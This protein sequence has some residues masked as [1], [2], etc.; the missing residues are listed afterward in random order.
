MGDID[1]SDGSH[2]SASS[3]T[4]E[5]PQDTAAPKLVQSWLSVAKS[6]TASWQRKVRA[7]HSQVTRSPQRECA[8]VSLSTELIDV[9]PDKLD[10]RTKTRR[11][12]WRTSPASVVTVVCPE[13]TMNGSAAEMSTDV[14]STSEQSSGHTT[15]SASDTSDGCYGLILGGHCLPREAWGRTFPFLAVLFVRVAL[16]GWDF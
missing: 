9:V 2:A 13:S 16:L 8:D 10:V 4:F 7:T 11:F 1:T 6:G 3:P 5:R 12:V 14:T 15:C